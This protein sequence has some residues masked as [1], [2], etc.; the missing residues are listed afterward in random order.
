MPVKPLPNSLKPL[1][2][3]LVSRLRRIVRRQIARG[4]G[5]ER[6]DS[7]LSRMKDVDHRSRYRKVENKPIGDYRVREMNVS[8]NFPGT[9]LVLKKVHQ[10]S[11]RDPSNSAGK[12]IRLVQSA[13]R[14]HNRSVKPKKYVLL[15]LHAYAV[16]NDVV[17]MSK[18][19]SPT[20]SEILNKREDKTGKGKRFFERM[21]KEHGVTMEQLKEAGLEL[22]EN[23][24]EGHYMISDHVAVAGF[25]NGKFVFVPLI[26]T[27]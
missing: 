27:Y 21:Q 24:P 7:A 9:E 13:V 1:P 3:T 19:N 22:N 5:N 15:Y 25:K 14:A 8:R 10:I 16:S 2:K 23:N 11:F 4:N 6:I 17:A 26:D 12:T 20:L 18:I